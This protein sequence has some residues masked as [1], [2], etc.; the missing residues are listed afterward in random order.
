MIEFDMIYDNKNHSWY[1]LQKEGV[2]LEIAERNQIKGRSN[3]R[4][5]IFGYLFQKGFI[6]LSQPIMRITRTFCHSLEASQKQQGEDKSKKSNVRAVFGDPLGAFWKN[7]KIPKTLAIG[8]KGKLNLLEI[9]GNPF[10]RER[11]LIRS[12]KPQPFHRHI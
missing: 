10:C 5:D 8:S 9:L 6:P 12:R 4:S 7:I 3:I 11:H 1:D 2:L